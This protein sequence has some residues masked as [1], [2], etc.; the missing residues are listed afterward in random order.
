M[1]RRFITL[2]LCFVDNIPDETIGGSW[3]VPLPCG[4]NCA[5]VQWKPV[6]SNGTEMMMFT[7]KG[8]STGYIAM[9]ISSDMKM[10]RL[11]WRIGFIL[12]DD[13]C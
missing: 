6:M 8:P 2:A 11:C 3:N 7:L 12:L 1:W 9:A 13:L 5:S 4:T 10:A